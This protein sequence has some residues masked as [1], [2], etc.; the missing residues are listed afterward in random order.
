MQISNDAKRA[1]LNCLQNAAW[2]S[3]N[4]QTYYN[5]LA[6][7]FF[8]VT[9]ISAVYT[10]SGTVTEST[11]LDD[12]KSDLV[13]TAT[14]EGGATEIVPSDGYTLSGTLET[15]TSTVTV[16]YASKTTTFTVT[17]TGSPYVTS[18][19]IHHWDG[20]DNTGSGHSTT[21]D[22]WKD[23]VGDF[24]LTRQ[25]STQVTW[26]T[27]HAA[28]V[29]GS[30]SYFLSAVGNIEDPN[31]KTIEVVIA[32]SAN[33]T[34][35]IIQPFFESGNASNAIGKISIYNDNTVGAKGQSGNTYSTGLSALT[36]LRSISATI[37]SYQVSSVFVNGTEAS[38][39]N[40]THSLTGSYNRMVVG[41]SK[42]S[43]G[44]NGYQFSGKVYAIRIYNRNLSASEIAQNY[45]TDV[46]RFSL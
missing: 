36:A 10:Q 40:K 14:Y 26:G 27:D 15:G 6:E 13:V 46:S 30:G 19:L 8:P 44:N 39:S 4:A 5:A 45:A 21:T 28:I 9:S 43:D 37:S 2:A 41:E 23:L 34:S 12:L 7:A 16:T 38:L 29:A 31:G 18:G 11:P 1:I 3:E 35:T 17:V 33:V 42:T 20:I 24:D 25:S 22:V 32:P